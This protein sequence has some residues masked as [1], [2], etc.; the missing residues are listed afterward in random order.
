[1]IGRRSPA[2][3]DSLA[4]LSEGAQGLVGRVKG[5]SDWWTCEFLLLARFNKEKYEEECIAETTW[6]MRSEGSSVA[7]P[8]HLSTCLLQGVLIWQRC[9][10]ADW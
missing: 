7:S 4:G 10:M 9:T 1:M 6:D 8:V 2:L 5:D 3:R